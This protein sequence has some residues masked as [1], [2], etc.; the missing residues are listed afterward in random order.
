[1]VD[2]FKAG[3][4]IINQFDTIWLVTIATTNVI[5]GVV[6]YHHDH[7]FIG[8]ASVSYQG[9]GIEWELMSEPLRLYNPPI[10]NVG[11]LVET[12]IDDVRMQLI[13][14]SER[15]GD[16]FACVDLNT[17]QYHIVEGFHLAKISSVTLL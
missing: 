5:S 9:A 15:L 13:I 17:G 7:A 12:V 3:D 14:Q 11:D 16:T 10:F 1:M 4:K 6:L 8:K 2:K